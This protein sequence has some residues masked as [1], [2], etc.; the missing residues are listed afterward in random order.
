MPFQK[1]RTINLGRTISF[2]GTRKSIKTQVEVVLE[3]DRNKERRREGK[4]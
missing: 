4:L 3:N 1:G 2:F